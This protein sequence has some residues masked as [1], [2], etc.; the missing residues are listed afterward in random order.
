MIG[1]QES[2]LL[3][4]GKVSPLQSESVKIKKKKQWHRRTTWPSFIRVF[5]FFSFEIQSSLALVPRT[6]PFLRSC[7]DKQKNRKDILDLRS[8]DSSAM[9]CLKMNPHDGIINIVV[10]TV[11]LNKGL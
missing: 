1:F 5:L 8:E 3:I 4:A 7:R 11:H 6:S 10:I 9:F 2:V